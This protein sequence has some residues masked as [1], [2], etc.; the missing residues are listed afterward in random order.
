M[1]AGCAARRRVQTAG[2]EGRDFLLADFAGGFDPVA[3]A[4]RCPRC[5]GLA[6]ACRSSRRL[7]RRKATGSPHGVGGRCIS[8]SS[9]LQA[10]SAL[11]QGDSHPYRDAQFVHI[12]DTAAA[13]LAAGEP[14]ISV[15]MKKKNSSETSRTPFGMASRRSAAGRSGARLPDPGIGPGGPRWRCRSGR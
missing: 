10:Q 14:V 7:R 15:D 5:A 11:L 8:R 12:N 1:S 2:E 4:L 3:A 6:K 13:A 9:S